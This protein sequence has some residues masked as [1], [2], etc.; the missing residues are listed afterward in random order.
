M[1][2]RS[3][4]AE[5]GADAD[6]ITAARAGDGGAY[7]L[8][9]QRHVEAAVKLAR[10]LV[11][12]PADRDD[13]VAEAFAR[14]LTA[15]RT[16]SGPTVAFRPYLLTTIRHVAV[17]LL[18]TR[19][20]QLPTEV[21]ELPEP[22]SHETDPALA[23]LERSLVARAF[24]MLP[25]R[26]SAVLWHTEVEQARPA[27]VG[28]LLGISP[29][30]VAALRYRAREGLRQAYLQLH[31]SGHARAACVPV[32][33][34][35]AAYVRN[36]LSAREVRK[37][38]RHLSRCPDCRTAHAEL[39]WINAT[40]RRAFVPVLLGVEASQAH[41][42]GHGAA[43]GHAPPRPSGGHATRLGRAFAH[44]RVLVGATALALAVCLPQ[45][46]SQ[47]PRPQRGLPRT[48]APARTAPGSA[49][50]PVHLSDPAHEASGPSVAA[51]P[52]L[53]AA[54]PSGTPIPSP[55]TPGQTPGSPGI[56]LQAK[57]SVGV[58]AQ[59]LLSLGVASTIGI[60]VADP[61]TAATGTV[62][63]SITLPSG[64]VLTGMPGSGSGWSCTL[65]SGAAQCT[66]QPLAAGSSALA[67]FSVLAIDLT[68][69]G[70][71]ALATATSGSL[72][73]HGQSA[74]LLQCPLG[75]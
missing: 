74:A 44:H 19:R 18:R 23:S 11:R 1:T 21:G 53:P 12:H 13:V 60:L 72:S 39:S 49:G 52:S 43:P 27:E 33:A 24:Q 71:Q 36:G 20:S 64:V 70:Q 30:A 28:L 16:G 63:T 47:P 40:L 66:H 5:T 26:W 65:T 54:A 62:S 8:L 61:G 22:V 25:E 75:L 38:D 55:G 2:Q 46:G 48:P 67:S 35:L 3:D 68:G 56:A 14:V 34:K 15:L 32:A 37:V 31:L 57:L 50:R 17:D 41:V 6:L 4:A 7:A 51:Q 42:P 45:L 10:H 73:A 29:S 59:G 69:C 9:Y 58:Q